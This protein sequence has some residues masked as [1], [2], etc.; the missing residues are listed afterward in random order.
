MA[1]EKIKVDGDYIEL[2]WDDQPSQKI[3][4]T[5]L[6][7]NCPCA[8][9]LKQRE[10]DDGRHFKVYRQD[11]VTIE[12]IKVVGQYGLSISWKDGHNTGIYEFRLLKQLQ[13][14]G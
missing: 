10:D 3:S 11:E 9:C 7:R 13:K 6:R 8:I 2:H 14:E 4:L 5:T 1:L 12:D